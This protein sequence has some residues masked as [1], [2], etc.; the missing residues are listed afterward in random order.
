M[1]YQSL[2]C[3]WKFIRPDISPSVEMEVVVVVVVLVVAKVV[4]VVTS[5]PQCEGSG[6]L[7]GPDL[8]P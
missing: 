2:Q 3:M 1:G 5:S 6:G 4:V 8:H 7:L